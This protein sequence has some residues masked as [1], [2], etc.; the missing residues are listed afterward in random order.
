VYGIPANI[1]ALQEIAD[2]NGIS[3]IF[4]AAHCFG[5]KYKGKSILEYGDYSILSL[6]ATKLFHTANGGLVVSKSAEAKQ[7]IDLL[8]NFGHNGPNNFDGPGINGKNSEL[9]AA[10]GLSI[11]PY[12]DEIIAKR[13]SQWSH[14]RNLLKSLDDQHFVS[15]SAETYHNG[16]YFPVLGFSEKVAQS[17]LDAL[18]KEGIEGRRYFNP[19]LNTIDYLKGE[20]CPVSEKIASSVICLPLY[21]S[22]E[23]R[24][25]TRIANIILSK[26]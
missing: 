20:E 9:N 5:V 19:S 17:I 10:L 18:S 14:Y 6:H 22:L 25:Q 11:L 2:A 13:R 4:D 23:T 8:R 24:Q 1:E 12:A 15:I 7:K 26:V 3:L 16:A 21:H